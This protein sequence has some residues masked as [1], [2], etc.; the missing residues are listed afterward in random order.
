[1]IAVDTSAV[2][3]I[4]FA[5]PE[6]AVFR[7]TLRDNG[8]LSISAM[9]VLEAET[10]ML[11]RLGPAFVP[12]VRDLLVRRGVQIIAFDD[13]QAKL[14]STAYAR[15]GKGFHRARLN[16]GDCAAYALA[17]SLNAPLLYKG[18]DFAQTDMVSASTAG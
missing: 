8:P 7:A 1:M 6:A 4:L 14:A 5:E 9:S 10:V 16:M 15:F 17:K 11:G 12:D 13:D 3:A 18:D 2:I